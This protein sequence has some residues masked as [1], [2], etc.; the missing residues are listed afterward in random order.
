MHFVMIRSLRRPAYRGE[1]QQDK[2]VRNESNHLTRTFVIVVCYA[3]A[4][5]L[6]AS[7]MIF[8]QAFLFERESI[9]AHSSRFYDICQKVSHSSHQG[10]ETEE[11]IVIFNH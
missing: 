6:S 8:D 2:V 4:A 11:F 5:V 7:S 9:V 3:S 1:S 10:H